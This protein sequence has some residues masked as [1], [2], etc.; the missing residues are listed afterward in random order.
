MFFCERKNYLFL[1]FILI[2]IFILM[3][4][5]LDLVG[6]GGKKE[7]MGFPGVEKTKS[8][9][10]EEKSDNLNS[11][12]KAMLKIKKA[13]FAGS[14]YPSEK[15][16]LK[17][18][19]E[20]FLSKIEGDVPA[21]QLVI[22]PHAGYV[23]SGQVAAYGFKALANFAALRKITSSTVFIIGMSHKEYLS[24][25]V[26][27][28]SDEWETPLGRV[29]LDRQ[30]IE[31]LSHK[32]VLAVE[33]NIFSEEHSLEVEIPFLQDMFS[34]FKIVPILVGD[35]SSENLQKFA[36]ILSEV[37][38]ENS[39]VVIS[40][41]LSH[42]PAYEDAK[43]ADART[44]KAILSG[45][46]TVFEKEIEKLQ[47]EKFPN[48]V[49]LACGQK[50]I[51]LGLFLAKELKL[52]K[53]KI[54]NFANSGDVTTDKNRVVGYGVV[55]FWSEEKS[56]KTEVKEDKKE[57]LKIARETLENYFTQKIVP[58]FKELA[59]KTEFAFL[60]EKSGVFVTLNKNGNLRGCIGLMESDKPLFETVP[61]M[62]LAAALH[63]QRFPNVTKEELPA[64]TYE[65]SVLSPMKKIEKIDEI[66]LGVHGVKVRNGR[67]EGVFLP[68]VATETG[69]NL[70]EFLAHLCTE[71]AGLSADCFKDPR[72]EIYVFEAEIISS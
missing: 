11:N 8:E 43:K 13:T 50:A 15:N 42:Y 12:Q 49:T 47:G 17:S 54:L 66:K 40:S 57:L 63:D 30:K 64:I 7:L 9:V 69:W 20:G 55:G 71:K 14:F 35:V 2:G 5:L 56:Q 6:R 3:F 28:S 37:I 65:I 51:S 67:N 41:D 32:T 52:D 53:K 29:P 31:E 58:D 62:A 38:D 68:Q 48:V 16:E 45:D 46:N 4:L 1:G 24:G 26:T 33:S 72:T 59:N 70:D 36:N 61:Q 44:L 18:A 21:S 22:V 27:D 19:I 39:L 34:D 60:L 23:Y 10:F 25:F